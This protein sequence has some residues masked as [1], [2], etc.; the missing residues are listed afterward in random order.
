MLIHIPVVI[1]IIS[2]VFLFYNIPP[3]IN[4]IYLRQNIPDV[5]KVLTLI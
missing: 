5:S 3:P 2:G 1:K 4:I